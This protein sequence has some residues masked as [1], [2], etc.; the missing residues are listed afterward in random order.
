MAWTPSSRRVSPVKEHLEETAVVTQDLPARDLPVSRHAGL[1]GDLR[2]GQLVLGRADH[3]DL[4][5]GI[6]ADRE[7]GGHG[8]RVDAERVTGGQP[9]LLRRGRGEARIADDVAGREDV[10]DARPERRVDREAPA[11][12][13]LEPGGGEVEGGGGGGRPIISDVGS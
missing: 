7:M 13:G 3:R 12:V 10:R 9:P 11:L 2:L 5:D 4:R 8:A 6:D 1:V